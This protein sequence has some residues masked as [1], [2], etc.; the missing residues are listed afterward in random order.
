MNGN[1]SFSLRE[2]FSFDVFCLYR[3]CDH[4]SLMNGKMSF[5]SLQCAWLS[6][7]L[8]VFSEEKKKLWSRLLQHNNLVLVLE[9]VLFFPLHFGNELSEQEILSWNA[10]ILL[11]LWWRDV[12]AMYH[13]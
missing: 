11:L 5:E 4:N 7:S 2:E 3:I 1:M 12:L 6:D 8:G 10:R 9:L 13:L